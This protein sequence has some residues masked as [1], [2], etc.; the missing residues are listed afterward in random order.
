M[1]R[2]TVVQNLHLMIDAQLF[3]PRHWFADAETCVALERELDEMG[4]QGIVPM[5]LLWVFLGLW[6]ECEYLS[7]LEGFG[8]IEETDTKRIG[9]LMDTGSDPGNLLRPIVQ[10]AYRDYYLPSGQLA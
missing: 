9:D 2:R 10:K 6:D 7:I 3:G 5:D 1:D 4:I 8:L